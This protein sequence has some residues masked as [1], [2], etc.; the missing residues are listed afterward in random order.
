M[1][2]KYIKLILSVLLDG[3]GII[4]YFFPQVGELIDVVWA[5]LST[6]ILLKMY[7]NKVA[8]Y[9]AVLGF[10]EELLPFTDIVPTFTITW[11][12]SNFDKEKN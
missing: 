7:K 5:P 11:V 6:Y 8:K 9:T 12:L 1:K 3:I 2:S 10:V 4:S